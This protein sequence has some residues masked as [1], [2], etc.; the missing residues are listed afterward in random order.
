MLG[1]MTCPRPGVRPRR[2]AELPAWYE[3]VLAEHRASGLSLSEFAEILGISSRS[4]ARWRRRL[5]G[6]AEAAAAASSTPPPESIPHRLFEVRPALSP[7]TPSAS[8]TLEAITI[9]L[10]GERR[11][12]VSP[13]FDSAEL[14]R[15]VRVL[16]A[17]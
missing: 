6:G 2:H 10:T 8:G 17:C 1:A 9:R 7:S 11:I 15:L 12:E 5:A 16:E 4:L 13:G 3:R 14:Q